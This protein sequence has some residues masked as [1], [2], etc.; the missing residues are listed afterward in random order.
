MQDA[1]RFLCGS[2]INDKSVCGSPTADDDPLATE[3]SV[4]ADKDQHFANTPKIDLI[5]GGAHL[6]GLETNG[7]LGFELLVGG[8]SKGGH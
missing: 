2:W 1:Q 5:S 3:S 4:V 8:G 7:H 6:D